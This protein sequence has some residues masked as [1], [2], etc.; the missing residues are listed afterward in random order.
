M[1]GDQAGAAKGTQKSQGNQTQVC[2]SLWLLFEGSHRMLFIPPASVRWLSTGTPSRLCDQSL[3][4]AHRRIPG[5]QK[6]SRSSAYTTV[7][8]QR[9]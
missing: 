2:K 6:G 3:Y 5:S 8:V 9:V 4:R 1:E 7:F